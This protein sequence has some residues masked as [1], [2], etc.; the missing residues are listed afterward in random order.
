MF[1]FSWFSA[2]LR[3]FSVFNSVHIQL[4]QREEAEYLHAGQLL[5]APLCL[6]IAQI[7]SLHLTRINLTVTKYLYIIRNMSKYV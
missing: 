2:G 6:L 7:L 1:L 3:V 5:S 4:H